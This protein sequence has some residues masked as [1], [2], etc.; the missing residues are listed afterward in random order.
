MQSSS[1]Y[2]VKD[3]GPVRRHPLHHP[4]TISGTLLQ[5]INQA[6]FWASVILLVANAGAFPLYSGARNT[7]MFCIYLSLIHFGDPLTQETW[8]LCGHY[9]I[10][11]SYLD[12]CMAH[13]LPPVTVTEADSNASRCIMTVTVYNSHITGG[14]VPTIQHTPH[15]DLVQVLTNLPRWSSATI[16][17]I[18][19]GQMHSIRD[20]TSGYTLL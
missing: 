9:L 3:V 14:T 2:H 20:A 10:S 15:G 12:V 4:S 17:C 6:R 1:C 13:T 8:N 7:F 18:I 5:P 19:P 16:I 11:M